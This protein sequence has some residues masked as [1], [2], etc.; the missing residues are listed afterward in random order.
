MRGASFAGL[1]RSSSASEMFSATV[2]VSNS[3]KCW[4]TMPMP[5]LRASAGLAIC[6][7]WPSHSTSPA[8]GR[9]TP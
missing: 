7:G 3:A 1:M 9:V 2:R 4:N 6:T 5:S 8:S